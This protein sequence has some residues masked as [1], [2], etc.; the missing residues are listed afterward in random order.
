M[1]AFITDGLFGDPRKAVHYYNEALQVLEWGKQ[2]WRNASKQDRGT[3]FED[4]F[5]R[6]VKSLRLDC[7][8]KVCSMLMNSAYMEQY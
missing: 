7:Y 3:I 8:M 1:T 6:G 5:L 4:T 2:V